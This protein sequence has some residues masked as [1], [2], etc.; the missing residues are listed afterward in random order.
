MCI[1]CRMRNALLCWLFLVTVDI[2]RD[3]LPQVTEL[4]FCTGIELG[5]CT[6]PSTVFSQPYG[7]KRLFGVLFMVSRVNAYSEWIWCTGTLITY[8]IYL[9][10]HDQVW[11]HRLRHIGRSMTSINIFLKFVS[12]VIIW[13]KNAPLET[14]VES[15]EGKPMLWNFALSF[16]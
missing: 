6:A 15:F 14:S 13:Y 7:E 9:F 8:H 5:R 1:I 4:P 12:C 3:W 10:W 2:V 11:R 16:N